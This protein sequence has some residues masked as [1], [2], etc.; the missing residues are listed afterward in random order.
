[1]V[2]CGGAN[3]AAPPTKAETTEVPKP[4]TSGSAEAPLK[5]GDAVF[6]QWTDGDWYPGTIAAI[7]AD[8]TYAVN[9]NDGDV[10]P[11]LSA[12]QVRRPPTIV[13]PKVE[14]ATP[15]TP[16]GKT[17]RAW[18][19]AFNSSDEARGRAFAEKYKHPLDQ[20]FQKQT[21]GFHLLSIEKSGQL[22]I[23]LVVKEKASATTAVG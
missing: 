1:M 21:G 4:A 8:G 5:V 14:P 6:G 23:T 18:L 7:N 10:S 9:Y 19:D 3:T 16:A 15:D 11:S 13:I 17:L 2:S 20:R 22:E 12:S